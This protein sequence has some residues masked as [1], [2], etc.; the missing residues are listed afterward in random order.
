MVRAPGEGSGLVTLDE[1]S[2]CF[3]LVHYT[4]QEYFERIRRDRF[5]EAPTTIAKICLTILAFPPFAVDV[6]YC[7]S[8]EKLRARLEQSRSWVMLPATGETT[9]PTK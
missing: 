2:N 6:G 8:E 9:F 5:P 1:E 7:P 3:R 4:T